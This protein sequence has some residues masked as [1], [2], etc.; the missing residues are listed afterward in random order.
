MVVGNSWEVVPS[1][2]TATFISVAAVRAHKTKK[3]I[4]SHT[5]TPLVPFQKENEFYID[6]II[7]RVVG[8][9]I[10]SL[11]RKPTTCKTAKRRDGQL[12]AT[13]T[14]HIAFAVTHLPE[15]I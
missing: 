10:F 2:T 6:A 8:Q 12:I 13:Q 1:T 5:G 14:K 11:V 15:R 9:T 7:R 3:R 4:G